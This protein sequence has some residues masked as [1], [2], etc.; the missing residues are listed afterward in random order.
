MRTHE[1]IYHSQ[2]RLRTD[3]DIRLLA[4]MRTPAPRIVPF[5]I[6]L[7]G[8]TRCGENYRMERREYTNRCTLLS[9]MGGLGYC[10]CDEGT[11][12]LAT[13]DI[14]ITHPGRD[15]VYYT[16]RQKLWQIQWFN[17]HG[18]LIG[19]LLNAYRLNHAWK[20]SGSDLNAEFRRGLEMLRDN[21]DMD[22]MAVFLLRLIQR[23]S[24]AAERDIAPPSDPA[25][26]RLVEY[27]NARINRE[28]SIAELAKAIGRSPSQVIRIF[29][30]HTGATPHDY[31][32]RARIDMAG[33]E[34]LYSNKSIKQI[35]FNAGF[36]NEFHFS[37]L[38]KRRT[39]LSPSDYRKRGTIR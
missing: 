19:G 30:R 37:S 17:L 11:V 10:E 38:F 35:A 2:Y 12:R 25:G 39:G 16:D 7:A 23:I 14:L 36:C 24:R 18:E 32:L 1:D 13:G 31:Q 5:N 8:V 9:V 21:C 4:P 3:F 20:V 33:N 29:R 34:L 6:M 28:I 27:L 22:E 26:V 15:A